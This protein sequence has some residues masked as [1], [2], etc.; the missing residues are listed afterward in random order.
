MMTQSLPQTRQMPAAG[1][2]AGLISGAVGLLDALPKSLALLAARVALA[3]P[4]YYS[5]LTKWDGFLALSDSAV[6]LFT[7]EFK[8]NLFG[9]QYGLPFPALMAL[10]AGLAEV[11]LPILLVLGLGTRFAALGLLAMTGVIQLVYPEAWHTF[12]L[13]WAAL[14]LTLVMF[15]GGKLTLDHLI[16]RWRNG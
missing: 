2:I 5:G 7:E 13:P 11:S 4:F 9:G 12:H 16:G 10:L 15:G 8:L 6:L 14:A 3:V 1:G